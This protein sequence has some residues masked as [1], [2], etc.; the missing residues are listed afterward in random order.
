MAHCVVDL[1]IS[2]E[3]N[4][5][6]YTIVSGKKI[7]VLVS[8]AIVAYV[9]FDICIVILVRKLVH[10]MLI[11]IE[12]NKL[13]RTFSSLKRGFPKCYFNSIRRVKSLLCGKL[14]DPFSSSFP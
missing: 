12:F 2:L 3:K 6:S 5:L 7:I 4:K 9:Y 14:N 11:S 13:Q 10:S 8:C 1:A